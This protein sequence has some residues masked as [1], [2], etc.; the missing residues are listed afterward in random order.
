MTKEISHVSNISKQLEGVHILYY[1]K[2]LERYIENAVS[3]IVSG[4]EQGDHI[5]YVENERVYPLVFENVKKLLTKE[6][7]AHLHY[8]NNFTFYWKNGNFHPPTIL[9]YFTELVEPYFGKDLS[10]RTWG[11][12]EW[13]D[14]EEIAQDIEE[15]ERGIE[16][17]MPVT[18][19]I[20]VCAYDAPRVSESFNKVLLDCH[21]Y[22]MTD[23]GITLITRKNN[24][25]VEQ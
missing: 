14:E 18:K 2:E 25:A 6:Q 20:S 10:F 4:I 24:N 5:L 8:V 12:I 3:F 13:S 19:A 15:Y 22:M 1:T 21:G 16:E 23:D 9:A 11:H 17:M 7:L